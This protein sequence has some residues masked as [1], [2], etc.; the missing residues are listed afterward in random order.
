VLAGAI[1][2]ALV[3]AAV[4]PLLDGPF[5]PAFKDRNLVVHLDGPPGTSRGEMSRIMASASGALRSVPGVSGV[6]GHVGRAV[7][8][9]QVV[10]VNSSELWVKIAS[11]ADYDKTKSSI[12]N[13]LEDYPGLT[14]SVLTYEK[15]RIRDVGAVDDRQAEDVASRSSDLDV[16]TGAD[17]RPLVVRVYGEDL[18][19]LDGQATRMRQLLSQVDGVVDPRVETVSR[20]PTVAIRVNLDSGLRHGIKPGDVRRQ[21]ATLLSG[22]QVGSVFQEEK[23]FDVVVRA[24]PGVRRNLSDVRNLLIDVQGGGHVRLG[25]VADVR[26]RS[27]PAVI[28]REASQRRVDVSAGVSGRSVGDVRD[29]VKNRIRDL[30]FP[31]EYHAEVVGNSAGNEATVSGMLGFA[32][33]AAVGIFL[34]LQAAFRSWRLAILAFLTLP[35]AIVGGL[36]ASLLD[37]T[38]FSLGATAGLFAVF[39]IAARSVIALIDHYQRLEQIDGKRRSPE[40]VVAG[41]GDRLAPILTTA[42]ATA[43]ALLPF[44]FLGNRAGLE[45]VNPMAVV[46][47]GGLV[48]SSLLSL[49]VMPALYLR[50]AGEP[51]PAV[52]PEDEL[53]HRWAGVEPVPAGG[54]SEPAPAQA[55]PRTTPARS[56]IRGGADAGIQPGGEQ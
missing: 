29:D 12:E 53:L 19:I 52:T 21:V 41:A 22:I 3:G 2:A 24:E 18:G 39:A 28:Q 7:T 49:F 40:L 11:D 37:G 56:P 23:V 50:F 45:I 30:R 54:P 46:V 44:V 16:L 4:I 10:D 26:V 55:P 34:L 43:L 17:G 36:L 31:L 42:V 9:D 25:S 6:A 14:R 51:R 20:Q 5:V 38:T 48:T 13:V 1:V 32:I 27:T 33:V 15:Q 47:L 8:G 35:L